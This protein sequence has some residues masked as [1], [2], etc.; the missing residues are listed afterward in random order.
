MELITTLLRGSNQC[1]KY[2][3]LSPTLTTRSRCFTVYKYLSLTLTSYLRYPISTYTGCNWPEKWE[4]LLFDVKHF[5]SCIA[6]L[7]LSCQNDKKLI[8]L[9]VYAMCMLWFIAKML[10]INWCPFFF[11]LK[12][13]EFLAAEK[14]INHGFQQSLQHW[15]QLCFLFL[16]YFARNQIW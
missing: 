11:S 15:M 5:F 12:F 4:M 9:K 2:C 6:I 10:K 16:L 8:M 7:I 1:K 3:K 13:L 14:C